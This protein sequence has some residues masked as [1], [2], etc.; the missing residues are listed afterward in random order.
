[1]TEPQTARIGLPTGVTL[2]VQL[3]GEGE[4]IVFL[5]GFPESHRCWRHQVHGLM[6]DHWIIAPDQRGFGGS[7]KPEGVDE[8][9]AEKPIADLIALADALGIDRFTPVGHDWGGV[10]AWMAARE[11]P[12][13]IARLV[14][15]NAPHPWIFQRSQIED[16]AQR[17]ASQ[18]VNLLRRPGAEAGITAMGLDT[19]FDR[20]I[21]ANADVSD[22]PAEER[23]AYIDDWKQPGALTAMTN[24]YR[25]SGLVVPEPGQEASLPLWTQR[26]FPPIGVPTLVL[27]GMKDTALLPVQLEGL[28][29]LVDDLRVVT[30]PD[31]GHFV[32]WEKPEIVTRAIRD[33]VAAT[34][35][36]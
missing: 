36:D 7:D 8:Y 1:M 22:L 26:P 29:K 15:V 25:A 19:F 14:I 33:F 9:R 23:Q 20:V 30:V 11:H 32:Q 13:R 4:P 17:V 27:W 2:N 31:A 28:E 18:Y 3:A 35:Q 21:G 6:A 16:E 10:I 34:P 24:W 5:H 12:D